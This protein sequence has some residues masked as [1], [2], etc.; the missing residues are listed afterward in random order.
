MPEAYQ[1]KLQSSGK[2]ELF[3]GSKRLSNGLVPLNGNNWHTLMLE[4]KGIQIRGYIN[5]Q[6]VTDISNSAYQH[7][8]AGVGS[9]FNNVD[10]DNFKIK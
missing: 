2:W 9:S 3:A 1:L 10:F 8:M 5:N 4:T 7:G 6:L